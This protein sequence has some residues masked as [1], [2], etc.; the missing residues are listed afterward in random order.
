MRRPDGRWVV[1]AADLGMELPVMIHRSR[2]HELIRTEF[3]PEVTVRTEYEVAS[4]AQDADGVT[5]DDDL[6]A[7]LVVAADGIRSVVRGAL[8]PQYQGPRYSGYT[9]YRGI[10][11]VDLDDGGGETWG[12]GH[13]FGF[14]QLI[15][16][17]YYWY[18]TANQ[19][20]GRRSEP[21]VFSTWHDPVPQ[22]IAGSETVLQNDIYDL[23]LPLVPFVR[24]RVVLLGD[25]AHAMTPNLGRG[26]CSAIEDAGAL[27]RHLASNDLPQALAAYDA[28]RRP[29]TT[30]LVKR[31]RALGRLAQV[32]NPL[33][34]ALRD[35]LLTAGGKLTRTWST[36]QPKRKARP[37]AARR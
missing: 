11:A 24:G 4:V 10:A 8:H 17:R 5:V 32:E 16:G 25:A 30:K 37:P 13:I 2:L 26:A 35:G 28:E 19:A 3:G 15:D 20:P 36:H 23:T 31:S 27:A 22:L 29:A 1:A 12:A 33:V 21:T 14:A 34:S 6:R 9:A 7:D 18:G